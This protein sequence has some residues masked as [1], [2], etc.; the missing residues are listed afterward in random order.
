MQSIRYPNLQVE[1]S[2]DE[3]A[4]DD[5]IGCYKY[6]SSSDDESDAVILFGLRTHFL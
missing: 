4:P 1:Q 3:N 6:E 2:N 5:I